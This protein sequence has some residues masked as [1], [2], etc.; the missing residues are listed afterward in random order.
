MVDDQD[1]ELD[2]KP[3]GI[4]CTSTDCERGLHCFRQTRRMRRDNVRGPCRE[5]GVN[6]V[7][8]E[9]LQ[10]HDLGDIAYTFDA[11]KHELVRHHFWHVPIDL[12]AVNHARRKGKGGVQ[13]AAIQRIRKSVASPNHPREGRQT[14]FLGNALYYGQHAVAACCRACIEEWHDIPRDRELSEEEIR[15]LAELVTL[16]VYHRLPELTE[17]GEKV[18]PIRNRSRELGP[19][20]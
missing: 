12:Q 10:Q 20:T 6:L 19:G 1:F 15:Y 4:K 3:L 16:Y 7:D 17:K 13:E 9:R 2:P 18:A 11:L 14:P 5:C 8:W